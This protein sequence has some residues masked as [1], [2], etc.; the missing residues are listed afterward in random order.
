MS[1]TPLLAALIA[2][3]ALA[4]FALGPT[5]PLLGLAALLGAAAVDAW[6]VRGE[7]SVRREVADLLSRGVAE[8]LAIDVSAPAATGVEIRQA[9]DADLELEPARV[10]GRRLE[11]E[12]LARRRGRHVLA[13]VAVRL[14]GP[15]GLASWTH[16]VGEELT[17]EV[18]PDLPAARRAAVAARL[19]VFRDPGFRGRGPLG[20][21][22]EFESVREYS[23]DDDIRQVNWRASAKLDRPMSNDYRLEQDRDLI[24][25]LDAGRLMRAPLGDRTRLDAAVDAVAALAAVADDVGDRLG[26]QAFDSEV[27]VWL[28]PGREGGRTGLRALYD[29]EPSEAEADYGGA[30]QQL[31]RA[32]RA[33]VFLF[34]D[35][36]EEVAARPLVEAMPVLARK[37][38]VTLVSPRD[39]DLHEA[40]AAAPPS[41]HG[42]LRASVA[43][44]V[45]EARRRAVATARS[46]GI[47]VV[48]A[49]AD[50]LASACVQAYL[51]A[52]RRARA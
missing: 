47:E 30:F 32:K 26:V 51:R 4:A 20:L 48:E 40:I 36:I 3:L 29:I 7:P 28:P 39:P 10:K 5:I 37:H 6:W 45:L 9:I 11:G 43:L 41:L 38:A 19:S 49:P 50:K 12:L 2:A 34:T 13:P 18:Y 21:G 35:L 42:A 24:C 27:R 23:P 33:L 52:K 16:E 8:P 25:A 31:E 1:P 46:V 15:L 22:T 14:R 17:V 44:D